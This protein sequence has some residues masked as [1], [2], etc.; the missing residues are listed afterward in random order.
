MSEDKKKSIRVALLGNEPKPMLAV[1]SFQSLD[2]LKR[3]EHLIS[4]LQKD[5]NGN[6]IRIV[7]GKQIIQIEEKIA[8][9][10]RMNE[11]INLWRMRSR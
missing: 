6:D 3:N 11:A 7:D 1:D 8:E 4:D 9:D 2:E 10:R 5:E